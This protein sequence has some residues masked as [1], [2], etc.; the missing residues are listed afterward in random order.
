MRDNPSQ[1]W[2]NFFLSRWFIIVAILV[3]VFLTISYIRAYYQER[4]IKDEIVKLQE[5]AKRLEAKKIEAIEMLSYMQ[6]QDFLK[7]KARTEFNLV[8]PGEK[9]AIIK[10]TYKNN[11]QNK[12]NMVKFDNTPNIIKWWNLFFK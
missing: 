2:K 3:I 4:L 10:D 1:K 5:E 6:T 8:N 7:E 12:E 9:S 11:G